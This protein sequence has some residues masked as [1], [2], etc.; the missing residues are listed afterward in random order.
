MVMNAPPQY[1]ALQEKL[2]MAKTDEEKQAILEEMIKVLPKHKGTENE[3]MM[4][5]KR[6]A[7]LRNK[8]SIIG[9]AYLGIKKVWPRVTIV[10]ERADEIG[11]K[12]GL[13]KLRDIYFGIDYIEG[14]KYQIVVMKKENKGIIEQSE[15]V[16]NEVKSKEEI[17][18]LLREKGIIKIRI[19]NTDLF[20]KEGESL[21]EILDRDEKNFT[22]KLFGPNTRFQGQPIGLKYIPKDGD[23]IKYDNK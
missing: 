2:K 1:Y 12:L 18:R 5:K 9:R 3:L 22:A 19:N 8:K 23:E 17:M 7:K 14:A 6:L 20:V 13:K 15:L 4:L 21:G 16:L 10:N 11:E